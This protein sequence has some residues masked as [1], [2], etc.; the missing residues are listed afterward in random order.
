MIKGMVN[1]LETRLA[2]QGGAA[3][4]WA[5]LIRALTVLEQNDR[6]RAILDEARGVFEGED[7]AQ[8][9]FDTVEA[10]LP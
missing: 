3:E 8:S 5:R 4:D 1:S 7:S 6:A 2:T 10:G 9:L